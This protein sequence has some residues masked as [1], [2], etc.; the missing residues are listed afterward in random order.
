MV[1][2][3][4]KSTVFYNYGNC[5]GFTYLKSADNKY[6][7]EQL[8]WTVDIS[9]YIETLMHVRAPACI[10]CLLHNGTREVAEWIRRLLSLVALFYGQIMILYEV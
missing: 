7:Q 6:S 10:D 1:K 2:F 9:V 8:F 4:S 5:S 3:W